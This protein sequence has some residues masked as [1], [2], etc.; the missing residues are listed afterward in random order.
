MQEE[1]KDRSKR[2][3]VG[4]M[5]NVKPLEQARNILGG[6]RKQKRVLSYTPYNKIEKKK[7]KLRSKIG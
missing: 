7:K 3:M 2:L 4:K 5:S 1:E 6:L